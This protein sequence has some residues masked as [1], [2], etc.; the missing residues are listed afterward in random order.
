MNT[1]RIAIVLGGVLGV[2]A[3]AFLW[4]GG[5]LPDAAAG[6][7]PN[8]RFSVDADETSEPGI[9]SAASYTVGN[10][11][12]VSF[13]ITHS[14]QS[15]DDYD[16][17]YLEVACCGGLVFIPTSDVDGDTVNESWDYTGLG[18]MTSDVPV[19]VPPSTGWLLGGSARI[20]GTTN[21]SGETAIATF[22]CVSPGTFPLHLLTVAEDPATYTATYRGP[23][24]PLP[25]DLHDATITCLAPQADVE[26]VD[27]YV[28]PFYCGDSDMDGDE[29]T[30][31]KVAPGTG[32]CCDNVDNDGNALTDG[33]D[34]KCMAHINEDGAPWGVDNEQ[35]GLIDE[36]PPVYAHGQACPWNGDDDCDGEVDEDPKNGLDDDGDTR[37]DEDPANGF[38]GIDNDGDGYV[39]EDGAG[40]YD[41]NGDTV[42]DEEQ[43]EGVDD[44]GDTS[45]DE[46]PLDSLR[47]DLPSPHEPH[48]LVK[49]VLRNNG[50]DATLAQDTTILDAPGWLA[51]AKEDGFTTCTD[52]LDNDGDGWVDVGD[53]ECL[54]PHVGEETAGLHACNDGLDNGDGHAMGDDLVDEA[55]SV[56]CGTMTEVSVECKE[57][58]DLIMAAPWYL[59][60]PSN[61]PRL[62]QY[63]G[64]EQYYDPNP[65]HPINKC[66]PCKMYMGTGVWATCGDLVG[67]PWQAGYCVAVDSVPTGGLE[68]LLGEEDIELPVGVDVVRERQSDLACE[69]GPSLHRF[70]IAD[71][72]GPITYPVEDPNPDNNQREMDMLVACSA[73]ADGYLT[74]LSGPSSPW[75][76]SVSTAEMQAVTVSANN[77]GASTQDFTVTLEAQSPGLGI[78]GPE[79][80][81]DYDGDTWADNVE[82][83]LYSDPR[84]AA[85]TPESLHAAGTCSDGLDN[86]GWLGQDA[87]DWKCIDTD[88]EGF[89]DIEEFIFG[90]GLNE[91]LDPGKVPET[92]QFPWTCDDDVDNDGDGTCDDDGCPAYPGVSESDSYDTDTWGDCDVHQ[93]GNVRP[94][95]MCASG[96]QSQAGA[97]YDVKLAGDGDLSA[98]INIPVSGV[99]PGV[100]S[101]V[102]GGLAFHCFA[103]GD[104]PLQAISASI[105]PANP[106]VVD[107]GPDSEEL[108]T[109][110]TGNA[111]CASIADLRTTGW[112]F[113][114]AW[115]N[116]LPIDE[117]EEWFTGQPIVNDGP[118]DA[119]Q[120]RVR[121]TLNVPQSCQAF[122]EVAY[123]GETMEIAQWT[124]YQINA[125]GWQSG[126]R[127]LVEGTDMSVGDRVYVKGSLSLPETTGE[128][129]AYLDLPDP[130][131]AGSYGVAYEDVGVMCQ[132][133][134]DQPF[135]FGSQNT[136][137]DWPATCDPTLGNISVNFVM[138]VPARDCS[139]TGDTDGD[140]FA[141]N[142][143]CYLDTD[144]WD[145]CRDLGVDG[146]D[147]WPLDINMDGRVTVVGDVLPYSGRIG[148]TGGPPPSTN[149]HQRLDLNMDNRITVVGDVLKFSG[150]IGQSCT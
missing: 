98:S 32:T 3:A 91:H 51:N 126:P 101:P 76:V 30:G 105:G 77:S 149:W 94:P 113:A 44:D 115:S 41:W 59:K 8:N 138:E 111:T 118:D 110:F 29:A 119:N 80:M 12:K 117:W 38:L 89:P 66:V 81:A 42:V 20:S 46:D 68:L 103:P 90:R 6:A 122:F 19:T 92:M 116:V 86:D 96:W 31:N 35:D 48:Y 1:K 18:G 120:V 69:G 36:D 13:D 147:A 85:S 139:I 53:P 136:H 9:Q 54:D 47:G 24:T 7:P 15:E 140:G 124:E 142:V 23:N 64:C 82:G 109:G 26:K 60:P 104:Y 71:W 62:L 78:G 99:A 72:V 133:P 128:I 70:G 79:G 17:Y 63:P 10:Q 75:D 97:T 107:L 143:E 40:R 4:G 61:D 11:F 134:G 106:H 130:I 65:L 58:D 56:D 121:K 84:N 137:A 22:R 135:F 52:G 131:L 148:A 43:L 146:D 112:S 102:V 127:T 25:T 141:D 49:E 100:P 5:L 14:G 144:P 123:A 129:F 21:A 93:L 73:Y 50:P 83:A 145:N 132:E 28:K 34:P 67:A 33:Q 114:P 39:D 150:K 74:G 45:V 57:P 125:G 88:G 2:M 95:V 37:I 87:A 27:L 108:S 55:D 16:R